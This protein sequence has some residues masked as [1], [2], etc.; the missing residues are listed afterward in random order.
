MAKAKSEMEI[1][2]TGKTVVANMTTLRKAQG[3]TLNQLSER[4][5]SAGRKLSVSAL[6]LISTGK[7]RVDVDDLVALAEA[8]NVSPATLLGEDAAAGNVVV[9]PLP[10]VLKLEGRL[11]RL[12]AKVGLTAA[13]EVT[14]GND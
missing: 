10:A 4:A 12:E 9:S 6:S 3:M 13:G 1:G 11:S 14:D 2:P 7:R 5:E 8:L